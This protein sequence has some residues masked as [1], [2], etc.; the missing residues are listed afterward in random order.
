[1]IKPGQ[2]CILRIDRNNPDDGKVVKALLCE[3]PA[4][5]SPV[6]KDLLPTWRINI[7]VT[8]HDSATWVVFQLPYAPEKHL[9]P[10]PDLDEPVEIYEECPFLC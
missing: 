6:N 7:P 5:A 9:H 1:M 10:L 8:W 3:T 4:N 2:W